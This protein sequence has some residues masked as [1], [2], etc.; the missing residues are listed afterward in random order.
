MK[1]C[2]LETI[3]SDLASQVP[4]RT[5]GNGDI[6]LSSRNLP[7]PPSEIATSELY[8][9]KGENCYNIWYK[10]DSLHFYARKETYRHLGL[11]ILSVLF[12]TE[13]SQV[14]IK[15]NHPHSHIKNLIIDFDSPDIDNL[16][17]G[18]NTQPLGFIYYAH[19][20]EK[21]PFDRCVLPEDLPCFELSNSKDVYCTDED[22][23]QR[24]TV[25][26]SGCDTGLAAFA[27]LLLNISVPHSELDEIQLEGESGFRGVGISSAEV[28]LWLPGSFG[29]M[30]EH[31]Q[32]SD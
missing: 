26:I 6:C 23:Q 13:V 19:L 25:T 14:N 16:R 31:W 29:W 4:T 22:W 2:D 18:Y 30:K 9:A 1:Q 5:D 20:T 21:H 24:D 12:H 3:Y 17:L 27:E 7:L 8:I 28:R 11:L 15:L 32:E 10:V